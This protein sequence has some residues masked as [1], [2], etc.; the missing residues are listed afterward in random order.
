MLI[1]AEAV[2]ALRW[3]AASSLVADLARLLET[4]CHQLEHDRR[5]A[6][7]S[8]GQALTLLRPSP[9]PACRGGLAAWQVRRL[10]RHID[11]HLDQPLHTEELCRLVQRSPGHF[12]RA[13]KQ[14]FGQTPHAYVIRRRLDRAA[15]LMLEPGAELREIALSCGFSDQA[16]LS[17]LFRQATGWTPAAWRRARLT[18]HDK[19]RSDCDSHR[20]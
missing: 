13:F 1:S 14:S 10:D 2:D 20:R 7:A 19:D 5:L 9:E 12:S 4:A 18:P 15:Q 3:P 17:R 6:E 16:H 8:I 11:Q